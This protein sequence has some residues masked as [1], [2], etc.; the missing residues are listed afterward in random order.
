MYFACLWSLL[1]ILITTPS[2]MLSPR[3][4]VSW[5]WGG[6]F[7]TD[8]ATLLYHRDCFQGVTR[9]LMSRIPGICLGANRKRVS[10]YFR[11]SWT[12]EGVVFE[13]KALSRRQRKTKPFYWVNV[14]CYKEVA[15]DSHIGSS[16]WLADS[17]PLYDKSRTQ[18]PSIFWFCHCLEPWHLLC[19][20]V[21]RKRRRHN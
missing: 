7:D 4:W 6:E 3:A 9:W 16:S 17:F 2:H 8:L 5:L 18:S 12:W 10:L 1:Q 13:N 21:E 14:S 11:W 20:V 15:G 19:L